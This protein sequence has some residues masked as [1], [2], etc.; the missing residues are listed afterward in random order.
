ML[1][2]GETLAGVTLL[3]FGNG[4]PDI[5]AS[6]ANT[7]G[8]TELMYTELLGAAAFVTGF[9][10]GLII[11][12]QPFKIVGRNN[13]RDVLFFLVAIVFIDHNIHDGH[14]SLGEGLATV[15]IYLVYIV[16]V[17]AEHIW[18]KQ[19]VKKLK[20]KS[21]IMSA[22][23]ASNEWTMDIQKEVED[24]EEIVEMQIKSRRTSSVIGNLEILDNCTKDVDDD[25]KENIFKTFIKSMNPIDKEDWE[26]SGKVS[27]LIMVL[28]VKFSSIFLNIS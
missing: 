10:G 16:Y 26:E 8:D 2:M 19:R 6:L 21:S 23:G 24:L 12:A 14:Y 22:S 28:K 9:V 20:R 17:F 7:S 18:M 25:E 11:L 5:F 1:R 15:A 3:A 13:V 27:K 4:S